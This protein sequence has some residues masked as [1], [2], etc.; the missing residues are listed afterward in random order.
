MIVERV[1]FNVKP[2]CME[3]LIELIKSENAISSFP[4]KWRMYSPGFGKY[5][6]FAMEFEFESLAELEKF[7]P[8]FFARPSAA[9]Y[10]QKWNEF[11]LPGGTN[12]TWYLE[13]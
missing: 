5:D 8:V 4:H 6:V 3:K 9:E 11:V 10:E 12:E 2:G 7:W 1:T 13:E